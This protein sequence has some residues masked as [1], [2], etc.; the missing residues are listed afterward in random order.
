M[1]RA[2]DIL[3]K[4]APAHF[5]TTLDWTSGY[6]QIPI[7]TKFIPL[8]LFIR[9]KNGYEFLYMPFGAK[10]SSQTFQRVIDGMLQSHREY[11]LGYSDDICVYSC[12]WEQH[13]LHLEK[14]LIEFKNIRMTLK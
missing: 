10:T 1:A 14:V 6:Y 4:I 8:T 7:D 5:I 2:D 3:R 9:H 12:E 11:A 13:L